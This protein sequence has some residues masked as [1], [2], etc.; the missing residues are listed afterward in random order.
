MKAE[1]TLRLLLGCLGTVTGDVGMSADAGPLPAAPYTLYG[2]STP[3]RVPK[4]PGEI[5]SPVLLAARCHWTQWGE[6]GWT[7]SVW[8]RGLGKSPPPL[9]VS[10]DDFLTWPARKG[11]LDRVP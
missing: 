11:P 9:S 7:R 6:K 3:L 2:T 5:D 10:R 8:T 1:T 4:G